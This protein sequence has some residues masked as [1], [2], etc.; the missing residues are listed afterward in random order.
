VEE[1]NLI[2]ASEAIDFPDVEMPE[3]V[4]EGDFVIVV[5]GVGYSA[6]WVSGVIY[7]GVF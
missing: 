4:E 1:D 3:L 5:G 2:D 6:I 7:L